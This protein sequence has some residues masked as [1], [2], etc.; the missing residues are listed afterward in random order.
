MKVLNLGPTGMVEGSGFWVCL[1]FRV[2]NS[3]IVL[4][5]SSWSFVE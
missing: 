4:L 1:V 3:G 5:R 2:S